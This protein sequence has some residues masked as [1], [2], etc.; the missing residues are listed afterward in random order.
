MTRTRAVA[1]VTMITAVGLVIVPAAQAQ[2]HVELGFHYGHWSVN[3]LRPV[4]EDLIGDFTDQIK[5]KMLDRVREEHPELREVNYT[6]IFEFDSGGPNFGFELRWYPRG[7]KG[8]F[9]LGLSM[10][11]TTM[12]VE[13]PELTSA[14]TLE[15]ETALTQA[16]FIAAAGGAVTLKALAFLLSFRWDLLPTDRVHPYVTLGFGMAGESALL[17]AVLD[18]HYAGTLTKPD[19][20]AEDFSESGT[21]T[22]RQLIDEDKQRKIDEGSEEEPFDL[23]VHFLP[24]LQLHFG[25]KGVITKNFHAL[26][27]FGVLDGFVL[28][29]GLAV[30]F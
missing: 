25:L 1:L 21:E 15:D 30:R 13:I 9:S 26:V 20:T 16:G 19:G 12:K 29:G 18:Y 22:V 17:D 27:D 28:R 4:I 10:E 3:L 11:R 24:F 14:I 2:G 23:P 5:D 7:E 6:R 8:S